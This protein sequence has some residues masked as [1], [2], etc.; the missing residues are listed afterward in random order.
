MKAM[1]IDDERHARNEVKI[2][3]QDLRPLEIIECASYENAIAD[4]NAIKPELIFLDVQLNG[5]NTGFDVLENI[6]YTP[7]VIFITA[8]DEY[9]IQAFENNAIDYLLKPIDKARFAKAFQKAIDAIEIKQTRQQSKLSM[10]DKVFVKD[11]NKCW[12]VKLSDIIYF[13]SMGNYTKVFFDEYNPMVLKSLNSF[14]L[15]LDEKH[16]FRTSRTQIVNINKIEKI[17]VNSTNVFQL[18]LCNNVQILLS[19]RQSVKFKDVMSF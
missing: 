2:A 16:F 18:N 17:I 4:I 12:F 7:Y 5:R 14:E 15:R 11:G 1:I 10:D 13:E 9:A 6:D 3:L 19:R 8:Y